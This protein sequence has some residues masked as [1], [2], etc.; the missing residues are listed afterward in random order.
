MRYLC[1]ILMAERLKDIICLL[2]YIIHSCQINS[3]NK[4]KYILSVLRN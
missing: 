4:I 2:Y 3:V 1:E